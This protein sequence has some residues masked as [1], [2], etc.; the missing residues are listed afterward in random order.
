VRTAGQLITILVN[1]KMDLPIWA[2]TNMVK[3]YAP[4]FF[5]TEQTPLILA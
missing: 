1:L 4:L 2:A 3:G 5:A